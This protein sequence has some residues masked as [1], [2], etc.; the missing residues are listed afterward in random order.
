MKNYTGRIINIKLVFLLF[1]LLLSMASATSLV[2]AIP[3]DIQSFDPFLVNEVA[4]ESI[5]KSVFDNLIER[6]FEG[7]LVSGLAESYRFTS[8]TSIELKLREDVSFHNSEPFNAKAV[9]FSVEHFLDPEMAYPNA[10][11]FSAIANIEIIND[12]TVILNLHHPDAAILDKLTAQLYMVPPEYYSEVG[13]QGFAK[14]PIGT[15]PFIFINHQRDV[16]TELRANENYWQGS[17][18][19][20][21]QVEQVTFRVIPEAATRIAEFVVGSADIIID[22]P[23]NQ[24]VR[25]ERVD[26]E[27]VA[28]EAATLMMVWFATTIYDDLLGDVRVRQALNYAVNTEVI[29]EVLQRG[30]GQRLAST[31]TP[32]SLG[33]SE[34]LTPYPYDP[35]KAR[36]LLKEANFPFDKELKLSVPPNINRL[37]AEAIQADLQKVGLKVSLELMDLNA[38]NDAWFRFSKPEPTELFIASWGGLFD[39][40]SEAFFLHTDYGAS[41][42]SN[43]EVDRLLETAQAEVKPEKRAELYKQI[44][45]LTH[46]DPV[47]IYLWTP[48]SLYGVSTKVKDWQPHP[49]GMVVVGEASLEE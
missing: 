17:Y 13:P 28:E 3:Q 4:G 7:E 48:S 11:Q 15:G 16:K 21:P 38:F 31:L 34:E 26:G 20:S 6:N 35:V 22:L 14:A 39:P 2:I 10:G 23:P 27:I 46:E 36:S 33:F 37:I 1:Y 30:Y 43:S 9:K 29:L 49:G 19:G 18:K 44:A 45:E 32:L 12:Y 42:Y 24:A 41:Y 40:A 25:I 8:D 5:A 47:G